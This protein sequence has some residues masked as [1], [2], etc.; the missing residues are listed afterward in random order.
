M[1]A[2]DETKTRRS[3]IRGTITYGA[4]FAALAS[5]RILDAND[6]V[7]IGVIGAG[8]RATRKERWKLVGRL[9]Q[10]MINQ[11]ASI[12]IL[13]AGAGGLSL[14]F[15]SNQNTKE[16]PITFKDGSIAFEAARSQ[17]PTSVWE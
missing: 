12:T 8:G 9:S 6:R 13:Q 1:Q 10:F 7:R 5:T 11:A 4:G 14:S 2:Q 3:F 16:R 17:I 15:T